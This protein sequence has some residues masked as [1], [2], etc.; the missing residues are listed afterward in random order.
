MGTCLIQRPGHLPVRGC[1]GRTSCSSPG[2]WLRLRLRLRTWRPA[3]SGVFTFRERST[4][5]RRPLSPLAGSGAAASLLP[6]GRALGS[7][8][9]RPGKTRVSRGPGDP[10]SPPL[11]CR[12]E[13]LPDSSA[14]ESHRGKGEERAAGHA[15]ARMGGPTRGR[16]LHSSSRGARRVFIGLKEENV[17]TQ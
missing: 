2:A 1:P 6:E 12:A 7:R 4:L 11:K 3:S 10:V 14:S 9:P 13:A 16:S 15:G 8:S 5:C 17:E